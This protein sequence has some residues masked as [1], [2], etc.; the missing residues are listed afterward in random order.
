MLHVAVIPMGDLRKMEIIWALPPLMEHYRQLA[1]DISVGNDMT[2]FTH[3]STWTSITISI[4]LQGEGIKRYDEE[5]IYTYVEQL[6]ENMHMFP[7]EHYLCGRTLFFE[8]NEQLLLD[9]LDF[10]RPQ[11]MLVLLYD[12]SY[13]NMIN[14]A[15][16]PWHGVRYKCQGQAN[17][18]VY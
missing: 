13:S 2:G 12:K 8:Y 17:V 3:N 11:G 18:F 1:L 15:E 10:L 5:S 6:A 16:E 4:Q 9:C 7:P 14:M